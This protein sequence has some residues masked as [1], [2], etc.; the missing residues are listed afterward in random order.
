MVWY[1]GRLAMATAE[2]VMPQVELSEGVF[3]LA[4][5]FSGAAI[6]LFIIERLFALHM[7]LAVDKDVYRDHAS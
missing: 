1:G 2:H 3:Y 4:L 7:N 6:L 5:P